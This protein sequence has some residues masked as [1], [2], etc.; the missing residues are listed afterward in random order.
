MHS[1]QPRL[2]GIIFA[3]LV[4]L[5]LTACETNN[6]KD[7]NA[8][9]SGIIITPTNPTTNPTLLDSVRLV[10]SAFIL[11]WSPPS[12]VPD[13]G[14]DI[15]LNGVDTGPQY[16][17]T[18]QTISIT[19]LNTTLPQCFAIQARY[20]EDDQ[21]TSSNEVCFTPDIANT[22]GTGVASLSWTA[23]VE[24]S[25]GTPLALSEITGY[26]VYHG[27]TSTNLSLSEVINDSSITS[28]TITNL[29]S[30]THY[31]AVTVY[32]TSGVESE[33]SNVVSKVIL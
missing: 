26:R 15:I 6:P 30:G 24:N 11:E 20:V 21:F 14:Y 32:T 33:F 5:V 19:G 18:S 10:D 3:F 23:P 7:S 29:P 1:S 17:T 8:P 13:G 2:S 12:A 9:S 16:R 4:T 27:T 22:Q 25:D 28:N 31:F